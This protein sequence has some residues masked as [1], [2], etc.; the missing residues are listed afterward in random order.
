MRL[1]LVG[2]REKTGHG[3]QVETSLLRNASFVIGLDYA[4]AMV[5]GLQPPAFDPD[6][7]GSPIGRAY[8]TADDRKI[9][10]AMPINWPQY[11]PRFARMLGLDE[12]MIERLTVDRRAAVSPEVHEEC[13]RIH[14]TKTL[15]EWTELG[16]AAGLT[17]S[18]VAT[19]PEYIESEQVQHAGSVA[20]LQHPLLG[21]VN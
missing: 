8:R 12:E 3:C 14:L 7:I 16:T 6:G 9:V 17:F 18:P 21:E 13:E 1:A 5:D 4:N 10:Y 15:A 20:R 19:L 2:R 11:W